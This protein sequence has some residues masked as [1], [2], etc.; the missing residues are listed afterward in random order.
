MMQMQPV[1]IRCLFLKKLKMVFVFSFKTA[2]LC[3]IEITLELILKRQP[4][5]VLRNFGARSRNH[6]RRRKAIS[7]TFSKCVVVPVPVAARSKA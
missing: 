2:A 3:A 1:T 5:Y 6:Y 4:V 7:I